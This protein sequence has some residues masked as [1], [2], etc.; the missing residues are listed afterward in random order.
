MF[1]KFRALSTFAG[2][3]ALLF[4]SVAFLATCSDDGGDEKP[5]SPSRPP[6]PSSGSVADPSVDI[7]TSTFEVYLTGSKQEYLN[8][9][10]IANI[11]IKDDSFDNKFDSVLIYLSYE[12]ASGRKDVLLNGDKKRPEDSEGRGFSWY[13]RDADRIDVSASEYCGKKLTV[14]YWAYAKKEANTPKG[15]DGREVTRELARCEEPS[16]SSVQSSS[17][18]V[19]K[20]FVQVSDG[21]KSNQ[22][23]GITLSTGATTSPSGADI[24]YNPTSSMI[25]AQND[26][27]IMERFY[28]ADIDGCSEFTSIPGLEL[29]TNV[30]TPA[31]TSQ[32]VPCRLSGEEY[33]SI[34][35][36]RFR[37]YLVKA[38][39]EEWSSNW[40]LIRSDT[41][42][43]DMP[44]GIDI[45][46][47][48]VN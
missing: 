13:A 38:S 25:I 18:V 21:V 15:F 10:F 6:V 33:N 2:F 8:V 31:N 3:V 26:F 44:E 27:K 12:S 46:I 16:S 11:T 40:F 47:W 41:R 4:L 32:F 19:S 45:K 36:T 29:S 20:Q 23:I 5:S 28:S 9:E 42:E 14:Q 7:S 39:S 35:Y 30:V 22:N 1:K 24:Y 43:M 37:Y 17:S 34:E 48:K